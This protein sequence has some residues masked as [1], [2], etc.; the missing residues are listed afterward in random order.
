[1]I[2]RT[3]AKVRKKRREHADRYQHLARQVELP[4][5]IAADIFIANLGVIDSL[6]SDLDQHQADLQNSHTE[7]SVQM[8]GLKLQHQKFAAGN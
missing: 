3:L 6:K 2:S 4:E 8:E 5:R 7:K 1:L